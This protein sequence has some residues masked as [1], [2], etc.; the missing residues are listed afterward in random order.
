MD[1]SLIS[2]KKLFNKHSH[3]FAKSYALL[4]TFFI[5]QPNSHRPIMSASGFAG[6]RSEAY[7]AGMTATT[8]AGIR[9]SMLMPIGPQ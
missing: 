9:V 6:S 1:Y 5:R 2:A 7:R 3:S 4:L 8:R